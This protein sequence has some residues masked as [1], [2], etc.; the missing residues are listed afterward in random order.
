MAAYKFAAGPG[1]DL[2]ALAKEL[3][4]DDM[5]SLPTPGSHAPLTR[6]LTACTF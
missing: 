1:V 3:E 5:V 6:P 4:N 2:E